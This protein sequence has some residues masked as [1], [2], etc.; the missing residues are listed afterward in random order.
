MLKPF[1]PGRFIVALSLIL[2]SGISPAQSISQADDVDQADEVERR[3]E[4]SYEGEIVATRSGVAVSLRDLDGRLADLTDDKRSDVVG[5]PERVA[6][7]LNGLLLTQFLAD[8]AIEHKL[9]AD[10][11][12]QAEIHVAAMEILAK[13]ER[14]RYVAERLLDDYTSQAREIY[15]VEPE[16]FRQPERVTFTH[17]LLRTDNPDADAAAVEERANELLE[18]ARNG[19]AVSDLALEYSQ[20]PS[21]Q[22]NRGYFPDVPT[23]DLEPGFRAGLR[24][25]DEGEIDLIRSAYGFHVVQVDE[26][27]PSRVQ[28][29]EEVA[30]KLRAQAR[31]DHSNEI[32]AAYAETFYEGDL[33]L[34]DGAVAKIIDRV[35]GSNND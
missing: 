12:V 32:F 22:D 16:A 4:L 9:L 19:E 15:L 33:Q 14:D 34:R 6:G 29:F 2:G 17:L 18:R 3:L 28:P 27:K 25:L 8:S 24:S 20:D 10:P 7:I 11:E 35:T 13:K 1:N 30:D 31:A 23:A 26:H 5:T 21:I